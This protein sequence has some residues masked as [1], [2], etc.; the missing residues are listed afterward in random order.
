[1]TH[2]RTLLG[3]ASMVTAAATAGALGTDPRSRWYAELRKPSWQPPPPVYGIVWTPLYGLIA[4]AGA[5][6]IDRADGAE[7]R[8]LWRAFGVNL[9]LNAAW[10]PLF[11][12]ARSPRGAFAEILA[13]NVSNLLLARRAARADRR[14]GLLLLPYAGWTAFAT[15]L[16]GSIVRLDS[17]PAGRRRAGG[18]RAA[19]RG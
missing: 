17:G 5:R 13:L 4:Y 14:A 10:P 16:N 12:R 7:R 9:A 15:L 6:A 19:R 11:F 8:A 3:T 18:H 1:M 2:A